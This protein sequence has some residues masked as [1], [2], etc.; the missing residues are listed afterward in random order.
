MQ[1]ILYAR[2]YCHLCEELADALVSWRARYDFEVRVVDIED[3]AELEARY[4]T[5]VP[6][7]CTQEGVELCHYRL[8]DARLRAH[9]EREA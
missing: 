8:D 2:S 9:L 5:L 3:D 7:L 1:L 4:G 6:V